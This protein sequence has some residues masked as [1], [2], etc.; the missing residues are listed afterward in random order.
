MLK[1]LPFNEEDF[2]ARELRSGVARHYYEH[3]FQNEKETLQ[4]PN[5]RFCNRIRNFMI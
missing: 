5:Q 3:R 1:D 2:Y 4:T